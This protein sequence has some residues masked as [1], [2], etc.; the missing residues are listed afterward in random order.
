[1]SLRY[2]RNCK[3]DLPL[4]AFTISRRASGG[5]YYSCKKCRSKK[6]AISKSSPYSYLQDLYRKVQI[7]KKRI[8][9]KNSFGARTD[10]KECMITQ[11]EFHERFVAQFEVF[12]L[13]CPLS[14]V[15]MTTTRGDKK[16]H[17]N[18]MTVDRIDNDA[19]YTRNNIMFISKQANTD[20]GSISLYS[21]AALDVFCSFLFPNKYNSIKRWVDDNLRE[22]VEYGHLRQKIFPCDREEFKKCKTWEDVIKINEKEQYKAMK[23]KEKNETQ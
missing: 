8:E 14:G 5:D 19:P 20:K 3:K 6:D 22:S 2:C 15:M 10:N 21:I 7:R 13:M 4:N 12:G 17:P 23:E 16:P 11:D 9:E 1:M 18:N